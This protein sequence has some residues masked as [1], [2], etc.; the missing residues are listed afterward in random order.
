MKIRP[1]SLRI[2]EQQEHH[3]VWHIIWVQQRIHDPVTCPCIHKCTGE[4]SNM[5][6]RS[7]SSSLISLCSHRFTWWSQ[8][9]AIIWAN[10]MCWRFLAL[11]CHCPS[12]CHH[13]GKHFEWNLSVFLFLFKSVVFFYSRPVLKS[14]FSTA[15][16]EIISKC[17]HF[18]W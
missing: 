3:K 7:K 14:W 10:L 15:I 11:T 5:H 16:Y 9:F 12:L 18:H 4:Y 13:V 8:N 17:K 2:R 6:I 1:W